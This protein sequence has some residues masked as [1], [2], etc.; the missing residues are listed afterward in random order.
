ERLSKAV[1]IALTGW[2]S[3]DDKRK[4]KEAGFDFHLTKPVDSSAVHSLLAG[5]PHATPVAS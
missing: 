3:A 1:L 2:G 4:T 5:L